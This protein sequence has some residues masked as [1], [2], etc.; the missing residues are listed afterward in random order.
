MCGGAGEAVDRLTNPVGC[1]DTEDVDRELDRQ[2]YEVSTDH[3]CCQR[4]HIPLF[5]D[6]ML[7]SIPNATP[8]LQ[9]ACILG[10]R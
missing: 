7:C 1:H 2:L 5:L 8:L 3:R 4:S 6:W 9:S 10:G